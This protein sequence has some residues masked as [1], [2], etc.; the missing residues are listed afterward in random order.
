MAGK[1]KTAY[2]RQVKTSRTEKEQG[3]HDIEQ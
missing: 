1:E 3:E 2:F